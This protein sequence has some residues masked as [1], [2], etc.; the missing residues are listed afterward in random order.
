VAF[1]IIALD[2]F[3]RLHLKKPSKF[4]KFSALTDLHFLK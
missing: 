3:F 4:L 1:L 2:V